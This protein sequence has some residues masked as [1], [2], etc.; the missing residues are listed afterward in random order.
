MKSGTLNLEQLT[1]WSEELPAKHSALQ[2]SDEEWMTSVVNSPL[3]L[4]DWLHAYARAGSSGKMSPVFCPAQEDETLVPSSGRWANSGMGM[5]TECWTLSSSES[6][7][8]AVECSLSDTLETGVL[9]RR[10]YLSA[11][12]CAGILRRADKR[13]KALPPNLESALR[14]VVEADPM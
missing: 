9:P 3:S 6:H 4:S 10:F 12:A 14:S 5:P 1:F 11:K 8:A 13:G 2:D 7:N